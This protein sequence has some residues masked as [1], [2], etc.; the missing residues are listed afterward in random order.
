MYIFNYIKCFS[1]I[2]G[3][4]I[5]PS[6]TIIH[7]KTNEDYQS[8]IIKFGTEFN[9]PENMLTGSLRASGTFLYPPNGGNQSAVII[10]LH[11]LQGKGSYGVDK[12]TFHELGHL[13]TINKFKGIS[14]KSAEHFFAAYVI[15]EAM[16]CYYS[17]LC[18]SQT[19]NLYDEGEDVKKEI[20]EDFD[21]FFET[22]SGHI[23]LANYDGKEA[24]FLTPT[25]VGDIIGYVA[26]ESFQYVNTLSTTEKKNFWKYCCNPRF[27]E[28]LYNISCN[29][30]EL[31]LQDHIDIATINSFLK[32][33]KCVLK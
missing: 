25:D 2:T 30:R 32:E 10:N 20:K 13:I 28:K 7:C 1:D 31:L 19:Y 8:E 5:P 9:V 6:T 12:V 15:K 18:L 27:S 17:Y 22:M 4:K 16:A 23:S 26:E 14:L 29:L 3:C 24:G 21:Y 11:K 33:F